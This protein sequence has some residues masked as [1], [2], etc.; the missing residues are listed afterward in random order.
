VSSSLQ[1]IVTLT[2]DRAEQNWK[3]WKYKQKFFLISI[4]VAAQ[5]SFNE[6]EFTDWAKWRMCEVDKEF[7][8]FFYFGIQFFIVPLQIFLTFHSMASNSNI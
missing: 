5:Q 2:P 7:E 3:T 8:F 1:K 6:E 4:S